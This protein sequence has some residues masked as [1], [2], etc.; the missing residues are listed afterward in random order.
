MESYV[1][2]Q[3]PLQEHDGH[4]TLQTRRL[5]VSPSPN[6]YLVIRSYQ[7]PNTYSE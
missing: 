3:D 5:T 2:P 4:F 6:N 1:T 7:L